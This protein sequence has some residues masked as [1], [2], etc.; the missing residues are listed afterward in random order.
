M[1]LSDILLLTLMY[2]IENSTLLDFLF[3]ST[4]YDVDQV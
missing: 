3:L 2:N 1:N 4:L